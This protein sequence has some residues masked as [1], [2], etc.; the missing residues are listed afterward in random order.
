M[1]TRNKSGTEIR[2]ERGTRRGRRD[3]L[4]YKEDATKSANSK[5]K[6]TC[7]Q[8]KERLR[9]KEKLRCQRRQQKQTHNGDVK[10]TTKNKTQVH[11]WVRAGK[12]NIKKS[13]KNTARKNRY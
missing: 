11:A 9:R 5:Q 12:E 2:M 7:K 1:E 13:R 8:R 4:K 6:A 10:I 3:K